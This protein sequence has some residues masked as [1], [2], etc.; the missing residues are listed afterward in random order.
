[1]FLLM[2]FSGA[3]IADKPL[4]REL[5]SSYQLKIDAF[6]SGV[7]SRKASKP[8][9]LTI[10]IKDSN[11]NAPRFD[12]TQYKIEVNEDVTVGSSLLSFTVADLDNGVNKEFDLQIL[13]ERFKY[14]FMI[15]KVKD[16]SY[17]L[18]LQ[19]QL[20]YEF[21]NVYY[22]ALNAK[23]QGVPSLE[24]SASV[25]SIFLFYQFFKFNCFFNKKSNL[26][27]YFYFFRIRIV[28]MDHI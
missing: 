20:D 15:R 25:S 21:Q 19:E 5:T 22:F 1:M 7:P 9:I 8:F 28:F 10:N 16:A 26:L 13:E 12:K 2:N 6:D 18:V 23:D 4:D 24:R 27:F 14:V 17:E 3:V 11:D